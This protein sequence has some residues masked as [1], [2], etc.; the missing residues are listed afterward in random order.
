MQHTM[1]VTY[2]LNLQPQQFDSQFVVSIKLKKEV[3][4]FFFEHATRN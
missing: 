4:G 3:R 1:N 2:I